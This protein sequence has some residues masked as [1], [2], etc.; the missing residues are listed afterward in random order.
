MSLG[1]YGNGFTRL[2]AEAVEIFELHQHARIF[3][4][5]VRVLVEVV[6]I[7]RGEGAGG[8]AG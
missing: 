6:P 4:Q 8:F 5:H 2:G 3:R 1:L 7:Q